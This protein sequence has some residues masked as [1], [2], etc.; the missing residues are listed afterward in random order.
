MQTGLAF[1]APTTG[2]TIEVNNPPQS[3]SLVVNQ[4][5]MWQQP[6]N[7]SGFGNPAGMLTNTT[8]TTATYVAPAYTGTSVCTNQSS[9]PPQQVSVTATSIADPTQSAV[10][11]IVINETQPCVTTSNQI[12]VTTPLGSQ[13][14]TSCSQT[15]GLAIIPPASGAGTLVQ[16]TGVFGTFNI[17]DGSG[18]G[19]P[20]G[21]QPFTW[22]ISS[23]APP[24]GLSLGPGTDS[25]KVV[26]SGTPTTSGCYTFGIQITDSTNVTSAPAT[27]N[28]VVLPPALKVQLPANLNALSVAQ[29][30]SVSL[31]DPGIPYPPSAFVASGGTPP[32]VWTMDS[33]GNVLPTGMSL[34]PLVSSTNVAVISGTPIAGQ[35]DGMNSQAT[36]IGSYPTNFTVND[37]QYPYPA[38]FH[39][40][41]GVLLPN[42][43]DVGVFPQS[44]FCTSVTAAPPIQGAAGT[45]SLSANAFLTGQ[46]AFLLK[47]FDA[48]GPIAI[49]GSVN[50]DGM[51]NVTAGEEDLT[52][53]SGSQSF[54]ITGGTY[55]LGL[56]SFAQSASKNSNYSR[57]CMALNLTNKSSSATTTTS[58]AFTLGGCSNQNMENAITRTSDM[59]CGLMSNGGTNVA[60][61]HFTTGHIIE[62]DDTT[63]TGSRTAGIL[64]LQ[65]SAAFSSGMSG[66]YAFGLSGWDSAGG[67]YAA[68]G[69]MQASAGAL[70]SV[71][72]DLNDA[73]IVSTALTGGSGSYGAIDSNGRSTGSLAVGT[74]TYSLALYTV[75][76]NEVLAITT[77]TLGS[78]HP[79]IAGEAI[80]SATSFGNAALQNGQIFRISG[81]VP[82]AGPVAGIPDVSV[83]QLTLDG[84]GSYSGTVYQDQ[85]G[86]LGTT[87]VSG[88]YLVDGNT[89]RTTFVAPLN[90]L[91]AHS[92]VAYATSPPNTLTRT[93]CSNPANCITGFLVGSD[94]TAQDGVLEFQSPLVAPPPPF[95]NGYVAG[96]YAYGTDEALDRATPL[97]EGNVLPIPSSSSTTS[98]SFNF[99]NTG[100]VPGAAQDVSYGSYGYCT[101]PSC[102][103]VSG[104]TL[105][106]SYTVNTNGTG[107]LGGGAVVSVTNGNVIFYIDESPINLDPSVVVA[108]Q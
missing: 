91:G 94:S 49:A 70:S 14:Y 96:D 103:L 83:G 100:V 33:N 48:N 45:S 35:D 71:A 18:A 37:S 50:V 79:V 65:N 89:G 64:R 60:A 82:P 19:T 22:Q 52:N 77:D 8:S 44:D 84:V 42:M 24:P 13:T 20:W 28:M 30:G 36:T 75:S 47:G 12:S 32:Y 53:S 11:I 63:G 92:F 72:A 73:G 95:N 57:G 1:T 61:G 97:L 15:T 5:V 2:V 69:S 6:Q 46:L 41:S 80:T 21:V 54:N 102:F 107:T 34:N 66:P 104:E 3:V 105:S 76:P 90:P 74:A 87:S 4:P 101:D 106:G 68:A 78:S 17:S 26:L 16:Q 43:S 23:G 56:S 62:F 38:V 108:E 67:H 93:A 86:T 55:I 88:N 85:G 10:T 51:G 29:S 40:A 58:F 7:A 59:A 99:G 31:S 25:S 98:G 39:V 81:L 9:L 27:F